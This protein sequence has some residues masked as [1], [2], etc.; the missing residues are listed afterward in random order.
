MA[1][2]LAG[3]SDRRP[4]AGTGEGLLTQTIVSAPADQDSPVVDAA[5]F[6]R[7]KRR[8]PPAPS[9]RQRITKGF[10]TSVSVEIQ[11][12]LVCRYSLIASCP[13]SRPMPLCLYPPNGAM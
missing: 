11:T 10:G 7:I 8:P 13:L 5:S 3:V 1:A 4:P 9:R 12:V 6:R 2:F